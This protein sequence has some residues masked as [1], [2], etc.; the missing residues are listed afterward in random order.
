MSVFLEACLLVH[1]LFRPLRLLQTLLWC[2][3]KMGLVVC[4][5][6]AHVL[7]TGSPILSEVTDQEVTLFYVASSGRVL[8]GTVVPLVLAGFS[9]G[10]FMVQPANMRGSSLT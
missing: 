7:N 3:R 10:L 1:F 6:D 2:L 9:F 5:H 8:S 4:V